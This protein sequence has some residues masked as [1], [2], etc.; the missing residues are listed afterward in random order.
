M[1]SMAQLF[2]V[3]IT[4]YKGLSDSK[5]ANN[6]ECQRLGINDIGVAWGSQRTVLWLF[7][8]DKVLSNR[9]N[10]NSL[11]AISIYNLS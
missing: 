5:A 9:L 11:S 2:G 10:Y 3:N 4:T 6:E 7:A 8:E 1:V